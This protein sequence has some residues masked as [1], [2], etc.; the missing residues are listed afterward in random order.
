MAIQVRIVPRM[1][2]RNKITGATVSV[3]GASPWWGPKEREDWETVQDG[4]T[5]F[6]IN[7]NTYGLGGPPFV[8]RE[9]LEAYLK[10]NSE[11]FEIVG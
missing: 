10:A 4:W 3:H 9:G 11:F 1:V 7:E 6:N 5:V 2:H 8:T